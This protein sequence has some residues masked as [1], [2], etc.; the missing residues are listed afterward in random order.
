MS[1]SDWFG[2]PPTSWRAAPLGYYF[3][4]VLG[5]MLNGSKHSGDETHAPYL[6]AGSIQPEHLVLDKTKT[7]AFTEAELAQ[8][9]LRKGDVVVVE[10]GAGYGRSHLLAEDMPGWGFQNHVARL[11]A[12]G[13][14]WPG[15]LLYCLKACL[16]SGFIEA[17]NRTATLPSLSRDV[18]RTLPIPIPPMLE[19]RVITSYLDLE[20][21][22]IDTLIEEQ[23][24]LI[25]MLRDRRQATAT[26]EL[27]TRVGTG[28]RLKWCLE[29]LD[30]RAGEMSAVLPLMS[31]SIDWGVRRRDEVT[32]DQARAADLS[33]YK[34]CR[35]GDLVINRMRAFQGALGLAPED[36]IVSPDYAVLRS[37]SQVNCEWLAAAMK[38]DRFVSEMA[39]RIKGIGSADLGAA[40]TPR[41]NVRDLCDIRLD[42][43]RPGVQA[44]EIGRLRRAVDDIDS[45]VSETERFIELARERRSA[46]ITAAVTGQIDVRKVA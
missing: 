23:Q 37:A 1:R 46:L 39:S 20:T 40:R 44:D 9:E 25:E 33:N 30:I 3:D 27:G 16:A 11:R 24:R 8:Y 45:L 10:G 34:V 28:E 19:Q 14:V 21:A 32:A 31:V 12:R 2:D 38:T 5:K 4:V 26:S 15:F 35:R 18:L 6:A 22:R 36:G 41:I 43:P 7:M 17:N 29:E 42:I 13:S